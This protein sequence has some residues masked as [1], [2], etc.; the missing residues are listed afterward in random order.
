MDFFTKLKPLTSH[1]YECPLARRRS[2]PHTVCCQ[3][4]RKGERER[5]TE[6]E[7]HRVKETERARVRAT[8]K[9]RRKEGN[10]SINQ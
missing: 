7:R 4:E 6:K 10:N 8:E 3:G 9:E 1:T 2:N 5:Q